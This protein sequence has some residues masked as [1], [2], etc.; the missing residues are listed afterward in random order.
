MVCI[1]KQINSAFQEFYSNLYKSEYHSNEE[2]MNNFFN[3]IPLPTLKIEEREKLETCFLETEGKSAIKALSSGKNPGEDGYS[4]IK[5]V[6]T[7]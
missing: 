2:D 4:F 1:Q 6:R 7:H 5:V 3:D